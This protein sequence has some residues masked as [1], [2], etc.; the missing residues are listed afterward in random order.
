[1]CAS[2]AAVDDMVAAGVVASKGVEGEGKGTGCGSED[3][4]SWDGLA[5]N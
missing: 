3:R 1:M 5:D 4:L 2:G